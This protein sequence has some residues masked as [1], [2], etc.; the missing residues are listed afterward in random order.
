[1][2]HDAPPYQAALKGFREFL[3]QSGVHAH[4]DVYNL[5]G[6]PAESDRVVQGIKRN[7]AR[8]VYTLG[9]YATEAAIHAE[10]DAPLTACLTRRG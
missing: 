2:S 5:R 1:M 3:E 8:L 10:I 7:G 6:D 9:A 4:Y